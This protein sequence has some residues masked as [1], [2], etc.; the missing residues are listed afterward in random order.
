MPSFIKLAAILILVVFYT[1][2]SIAEVIYSDE[3]EQN[4]N[5]KTYTVQSL[6]S[7]PDSDNFVIDNQTY[8]PKTYC[9]MA[10]GDRVKFV[11]N[12]PDDCVDA[13]LLNLRTKQICN[14][15]CDH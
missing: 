15:W 13:Q 11:E 14:V 8:D 7:N 5:T 10:V 3:E 4:I 6:D 2:T 9:D 1:Q 12:T